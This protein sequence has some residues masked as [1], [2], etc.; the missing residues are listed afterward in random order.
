M[1]AE[2]TAQTGNDYLF[3]MAMC[4]LGNLQVGIPNEKYANLKDIVR[5]A[6]LEAAVAALDKRG[7]M[8]VASCIRNAVDAETRDWEVKL[9]QNGEDKA[10]VLKWGDEAAVYFPGTVLKD[11]KMLKADIDA[12][13]IDFT[14]S[15]GTHCHVD[16]G[17]L[18]RMYH[19]RG[20]IKDE[21]NAVSPSQIS[22]NGYSLGA[23]MATLFALDLEKDM[24]RRI[25]TVCTFA[26]PHT[27]DHAFAQA[28]ERELADGH[29]A[30]G[31]LFH[32]RNVEDPVTYVAPWFV[33]T[34][35]YDIGIDGNGNNGPS[36]KGEMPETIWHFMEDFNINH[37]MPMAYMDGIQ[38]LQQKQDVS[39]VLGSASAERLHTQGRFILGA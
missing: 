35:G 19:V 29:V 12:V 22:V 20:M 25:K 23:G 8:T 11:I 21:L 1:A 27:G 10:L 2:E 13:P 5:H 6:D 37:H 9:V 16:Q 4:V 3:R 31:K 34:P 15:G 26:S 32:V 17:F 18:N 30:A 7:S 14:T 39:S 28:L 33:K 24:Q 36:V 38:A